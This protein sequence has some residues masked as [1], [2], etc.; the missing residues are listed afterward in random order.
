MYYNYEH[1]GSGA[2]ALQRGAQVEK[3]R[4][5]GKVSHV[6]LSLK[7]SVEVVGTNSVS[8]YLIIVFC[9]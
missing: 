3:A 2:G 5:D 1:S 9:R 7:Q 8:K 4:Q 6:L